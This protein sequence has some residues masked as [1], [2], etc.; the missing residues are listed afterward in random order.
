MVEPPPTDF[1]LQTACKNLPYIF[2]PSH[3][4][5]TWQK[6]APAA[7]ADERGTTYLAPPSTSMGGQEQLLCAAVLALFFQGRTKSKA[8]S[9]K[10]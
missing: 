8:G 9:L 2:L 1:L 10:G 3:F 5:L 6:T 7:C 4:F